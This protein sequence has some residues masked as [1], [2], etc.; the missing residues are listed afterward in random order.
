[1]KFL[2]YLFLCVFPP[3]GDCDKMNSIRMEFHKPNNK[4]KI[5]KLIKSCN[6]DKCHKTVPYKAVAIMQQAKYEW[7]P[8]QKF[9]HFLEGKKLLENY[10]HQNPDDIEGRYTR[11]LAQKNTPFFLGYKNNM[12]SDKRYILENITAS[13]L[14]TTYQKIILKNINE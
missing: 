3:D 4:E 10:I 7:S 2:I 9:H 6:Q 8:F 13:N 11:F 5:I 12:E 1:M 14:P